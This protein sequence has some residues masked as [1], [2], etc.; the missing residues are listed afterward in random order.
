MASPLTS[1]VPQCISCVRRTLGYMG[2]KV[3]FPAQQ[4]RGKKKLSRT[5]N[6]VNALLLKDIKGF[7]KKGNVVSI[8]AGVM[9]NQWYPRRQAEYAT[10]ARM[11]ELGLRQEDVIEGGLLPANEDAIPNEAAK[12]A[13]DALLSAEDAPKPEGYVPFLRA[14]KPRKAEKIV[15]PSAPEA[16]KGPETPTPVEASAILS[17]VLPEHQDITFLRTPLTTAPAIPRR[18]SPSLPAKAAV[19]VAAGGKTSIKPLQTGI[20]GSV[21]TTDIALQV[22]SFLAKHRKGALINVSPDEIAFV[23][24][25][26]DAT[27]VKHLGDFRIDIKLRGAPTAIRRTSVDTKLRLAIWRISGFLFG[28]PKGNLTAIF[29]P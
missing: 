12:A 5:P 18:M 3:L 16:E 13:A 11:K 27:R 29:Q 15:P 1:R 19:S 21:S 9:R 10:A 20:F 28:I 23:D 14:E 6:K 26:E 2:E 17:S 24:E 22:N 4:I 8:V 25:L 7:G